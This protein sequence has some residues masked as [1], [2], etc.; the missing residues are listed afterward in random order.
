MTPID[1]KNSNVVY[2]KDQ[3][4]YRPLPAYRQDDRD[5]IVISCW[6]LTW[7]ERLKLLWTGRLWMMQMTFGRTLQ[8]Q[9]PMIDYPFKS[10]N[11]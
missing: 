11:E 2:A 6:K 1:F 5:G 4:E 9:L 8:P 7:L 10:E 3:E